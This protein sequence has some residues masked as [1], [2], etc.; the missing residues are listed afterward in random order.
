M[1]SRLDP[2]RQSVESPAEERT[3][4][5]GDDGAAP[6]AA[7]VEPPV[8]GA[9]AAMET[10]GEPARTPEV[11]WERVPAEPPPQ[12][13]ARTPSRPAGPNVML[14]LV[15]WVAGV[16]ALYEALSVRGPV[17]LIQPGIWRVTA[18]PEAL[19][20]F[21]YLALGIGVLLVSFEWYYWS[22]RPRWLNWLTV[23]GFVLILV[24]IAC[25]IQSPSPGRRI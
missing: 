19:D 7:E 21:G 1:E 2:E 15:T 5:A 6:V 20:L 10:S 18:R 3:A 12:E 9:A 8:E 17:L 25:L 4:P 14:L 23:P 16:T 24:G 11:A 22:R 13:A